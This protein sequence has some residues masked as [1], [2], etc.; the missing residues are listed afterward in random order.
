M[1]NL[2]QPTTDGFVLKQEDLSDL[3]VLQNHNLLIALGGVA[4]RRQSGVASH[5]GPMPVWVSS[6]SW[7]RRLRD[8][9]VLIFELFTDLFRAT[10]SAGLATIQ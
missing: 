3:Q 8:D 7:Q 9:D 5:Y 6:N 10:F 2:D 4:A 1:S